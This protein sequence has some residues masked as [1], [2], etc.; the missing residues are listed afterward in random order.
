MHVKVCSFLLIALFLR[1]AESTVI[2]MQSSSLLTDGTKPTAR[3]ALIT[4]SLASNQSAPKRKLEL[5]KSDEKTREIVKI[6]KEIAAAE[7]LMKQYEGKII[8]RDALYQPARKKS[9]SPS[10][11]CWRC[12]STGRRTARKS[13]C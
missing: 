9:R 7:G 12:P 3:S 11:T 13:R 10:E 2:K 1:H 6:R 8:R 5:F 4:N